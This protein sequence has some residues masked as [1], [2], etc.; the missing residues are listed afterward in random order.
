[1]GKANKLTNDFA[2]SYS[3]LKKIA[4]QLEDSQEEDLETVL[5]VVPKAIEHHKNCK[6]RID[7]IRKILESK[8]EE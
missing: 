3:E 4:A 2:H 6:A 5:E 7:E 8:M 1:M